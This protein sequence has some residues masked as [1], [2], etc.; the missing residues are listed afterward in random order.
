[1]AA[2]IAM[3]C[4]TVLRLGEVALATP[5]AS[6]RWPPRLRCYPIRDIFWSYPIYLG[7][8]GYAIPFE[9]EELSDIIWSEVLSAV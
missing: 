4:C 9:S 1:M 7:R 2:T 5:N 8:R 6:H 3:L